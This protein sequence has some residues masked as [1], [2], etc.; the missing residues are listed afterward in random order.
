MKI[1]RLSLAALLLTLSASAQQKTNT[2]PTVCLLSS[3]AV[4]SLCSAREAAARNEATRQS[5]AQ[6]HIETHRTGFQQTETPQFVFATKNNDF[7]FSLGGFV[8]LRAGYDFKGT[9]DNRDFITYD[10]PVPGTGKDRQ[11]L[12]LEA[13]T[14]RLYLK[15]ITNTRALGRIVAYVELDFHGG[16]ENSYTPRLRLAYISFMG[17]TLGR[18][19]TT[20][21]DLKSTP[22]TVD[23]QGPGAYPHAY[24]TMIRYERTFADKRMSFGIAAELPSVTGTYGE[25]FESMNQRVPDLPMYLQY[26]WG[27]ER[28]SHIRASGIIRNMYIH[29]VTNNSNTSLLGWGVQLSGTVK[30]CDFLRFYGNGVY[31]EGIAPFLQDL[32]GSGLD[33]TP[34]P[35]APTHIQTMPM[36]GWQAAG[37]ISITPR[38]SVAGGYSVVRVERNNGYYTDDQYKRGQYLFGNVFYAI[39]PRCRA[40]VEYLHGSRKNMDD[41]KNTA[42]RINMMVKYYF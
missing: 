5:A 11:K 6:D 21:C 2:Q 20:F 25:H 8:S 9:T 19:I 13:A 38:L 36:W 33:F 3:H 30:C 17:L 4:D 16:A 41:Q 40:A 34:N 35:T 1:F 27:K 28:D 42:N 14:S 37:Q 7:S 15:A 39:T 10:I 32:Q 12:M 23:F 22:T 26:A 31:G 24:S 29:N 18:D